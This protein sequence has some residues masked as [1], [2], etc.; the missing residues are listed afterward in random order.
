MSGLPKKEWLRVDQVCEHYQIPRSTLYSWI[1]SGKLPASRIGESKLIRIHR[2]D[3]EKI[4][5]D[6]NQ[7]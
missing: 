3:A 2:D 4:M 6:L 5:H 7:Q 1:D